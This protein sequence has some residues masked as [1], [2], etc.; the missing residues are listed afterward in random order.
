MKFKNIRKADIG[1]KTTLCEKKKL[2]RNNL[3]QMDI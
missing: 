2:Y 1:T 3:T